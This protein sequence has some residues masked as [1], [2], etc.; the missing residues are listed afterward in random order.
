MAGWFN[1]QT[2]SASIRSL[3]GKTV[4]T[5]WRDS[6]TIW[7]HDFMK[8]ATG[9][10]TQFTEL[11]YTHSTI[12]DEWYHIAYTYDPDHKSALYVDGILVGSNPTGKVTPY[13]KPKEHVHI[14]RN[15][16][17]GPKEEMLGTIDNIRLYNKPLSPE[18]ISSILKRESES[19]RK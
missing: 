15:F 8:G 18:E 2:V 6:Y 12:Q 16:G 14:G 13:S 4:G 19:V 10:T 7:R 17:D 1:F 5:E 3:I 11:A 9:T